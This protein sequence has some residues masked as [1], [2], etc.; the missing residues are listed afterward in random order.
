MVFVIPVKIVALK[1]PVGM[2]AK[3]FA[4]VFDNIFEG[5]CETGISQFIGDAKRTDIFNQT[6]D[7][8][9]GGELVV[10]LFSLRIKI[11]ARNRNI[12]VL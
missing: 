4:L 8:G 2:V 3:S 10:D 12:V 9:D 1:A 7:G 6:L 5:F 11:T